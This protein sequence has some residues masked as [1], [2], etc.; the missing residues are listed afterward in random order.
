VIRGAGVTGV[1]AAAAAALAACGNIGLHES[2]QRKRSGPVV[3]GPTS[4]V[5][6][7]GGKIYPDQVVVV[8]QPT[9]GTFRCFGATCTHAGCLL[10][11]VSGG[12]INCVCHGSEFSITDGSV[13]RP[14]AEQ[15]L[16]S[17]RITVANG[18]ITLD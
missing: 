14:P 11:D 17:E 5:P 2:Q 8:T 15:P 12:T 7:G 6:V 9:A 13:V 4:D 16:P 18:S 10:H 3:L 1:G